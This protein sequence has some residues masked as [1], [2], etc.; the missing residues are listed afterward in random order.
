MQRTR[1][2]IRMEVNADRAKAL[3]DAVRRR[4][5]RGEASH[6]ELKA[7]LFKA[8]TKYFTELAE[9]TTEF[10]PLL[11]FGLRDPKQYTELM[12][13]VKRDLESASRDAKNL[14]DTVVSGFNLSSVLAQQLE[15]TVKKVTTKSQDLQ[16]LS[17][18]FAEETIVAGDDFADDSRIDK[19]ANLEVPG[20]ELPA[21]QNTMTLK[22]E[23]AVNVLQDQDVIIRV[24][25]S[26]RIYEGCFYALNQQARPEGG[27]F[28]FSG[29]DNSLETD[30]SASGTPKDL[31]KRMNQWRADPTGPARIQT[32]DGEMERSKITAKQGVVW[33]QTGGSWGP[34]TRVEWD[35]LANN[36]HV[37]PAFADDP[38]LMRPI[39]AVAETD[40]GAPLEDK[41][42]IRARMLDGN[43]DTFWEAEF[44]IDAS[45][46]LKAPSPP[47]ATQAAAKSPD[48]VHNQFKD[49]WQAKFGGGAQSEAPADQQE[50]SV[51]LSLGELIDKISGPA[52][53]KMDL[54]VVI[55][56]ELKTPKI[57]NWLNLVPHNFSDTAWLEVLD[58]STSIDGATWEEVEGL[59]DAKFE[60]ILTEEA[61]AEMTPEEV[62]TTMAPSKFQ[63]TGHGVWT[64]P[65]KEVKFI[66]FKLLQK[67]PVPAPYDV[68]MVELTQ[69]VTS[70]HTATESW[71]LL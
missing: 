27:Q 13:G 48:A 29:A 16:H 10:Q 43:P 64:F 30:A 67:T 41:R 18:T 17:E 38:S 1:Q 24:L 50:A 2:P 68:L 7:Q 59:H 19:N 37:D 15:S 35:M 32:P 49:D 44:V 52:I 61:N 57:I 58:V 51:Q 26:F 25:S 28:H 47:P 23:S 60:N 45:E 20:C 11:S 3:L 66:R 6:P 65:A 8:F 71:G 12:E 22:R 54:D 31:V 69:T 62:A 40:R 70:T 55:I 4:I 39:P 46:A 36:Y 9:P 34:F 42:K 33:A 53:D 14:A 21:N 63:Y 5:E 56:L